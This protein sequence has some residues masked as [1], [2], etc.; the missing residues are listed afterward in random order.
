MATPHGAGGRTGA[1]T[2]W[3]MRSSPRRPRARALQRAAHA[4]NARAHSCGS[5]VS[6]CG[7]AL[8]PRRPATPAPRA[9]RGR[10]DTRPRTRPG[11]P[12][13]AGRGGAVGGGPQ[14]HHHA[15]R[16]TAPFSL[17]Q[18]RPPHRRPLQPAPRAAPGA[19]CPTTSPHA[20]YYSGDMS[21]ARG[22]SYAPRTTTH[23]STASL[24]VC[25]MMSQATRVLPEVTKAC[26]PPLHQL[27][28]WC[29]GA[30]RRASWLVGGGC[31]RWASDGARVR[32]VTPR[33]RP[34]TPRSVHKIS[35]DQRRELCWSL[36]TLL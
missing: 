13:H 15:T 20:T 29:R 32:R 5:G 26:D 35:N 4:A 16:P 10:A 22:G 7:S 23:V 14:N 1:R 33:G 9:S 17:A 8:R 36:E 19:P 27:L 30:R 11:T 34:L 24:Q 12:P 6:L 31:G 28:T 25:S 18:G 3:T 2:M 21:A